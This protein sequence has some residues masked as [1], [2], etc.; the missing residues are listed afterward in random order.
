MLELLN[1]SFEMTHLVG[2]LFDLLILA[3]GSRLQSTLASN[4]ILILLSD[5][6]SF[7][8]FLFVLLKLSCQLLNLLVLILNHLLLSFR[9]R[10]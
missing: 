9:I 8:G 7:C 6:V 4:Q 10:F 3:G 2:Q 5:F 1:N